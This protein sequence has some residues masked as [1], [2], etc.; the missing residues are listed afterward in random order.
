MFTCIEVRRPWGHMYWETGNENLRYV[1]IIFIYMRTHSQSQ[2]PGK[3]LQEK[4]NSIPCRG[5]QNSLPLL[6]LSIEKK[7]VH[8]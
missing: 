3:Q 7:N 2:D 1:M 5:N 4:N 8:F 6:M